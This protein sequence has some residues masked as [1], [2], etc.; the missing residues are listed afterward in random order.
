MK[1]S[2]FSIMHFLRL[3]IF[4]MVCLNLLYLNIVVLKNNHNTSFLSYNSSVVEEEATSQQ[5]ACGEDCI[6]NI[7]GAIYQ[8][9]TSAQTN[10]ENTSVVQ[11]SASEA[12]EYYIS[13]GS[14]TSNAE[15]W[16]DVNGLQA[17]IDTSKYPNIKSVVFEA[18]VYIPTGNQKAYVRLYNVTDKHPVWFSE[19]FLDGGQA[20][21]LVS[22]PITLDSGNKL[23]SVQMKTSLKFV[24]EL[25]QS[26]VRIV[27]Q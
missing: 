5:E 2:T 3:G 19:V 22:D 23:Y 20:K 24:S 13:F 12:K 18:S 10:Q 25:A 9:T 26:R 15:D 1:L 4:V 27:L 21:L 17:Y 11:T 7:Y 16:T 14:G 8:A 6:E